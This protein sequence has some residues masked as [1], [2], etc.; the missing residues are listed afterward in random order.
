MIGR[1]SVRLA[2][3]LALALMA[4]LF[5]ACDDSTD[6]D[7]SALFQASLTGA[8]EVPPV[9]TAA[10]GTARFE[11]NDDETAINYTLNIG[12]LT[13]ATVS[14]IHFGAT[15]VNGPVIVFL[16]GPINAPGVNF[17]NQQVVKSGTIT[18]ND[19]QPAA[20]FDGQFSTLIN[21]MRAG[22]TYVNVHSVAHAAGEIRSQIVLQD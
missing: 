3:P 17:T 21:E 7:I 22:N 5:V 10:T 19:V 14:H 18:A 8:N 12:S 4:G 11:L 1:G 2:A 15:G 13:G 9:T 16:W 20:G 6:P